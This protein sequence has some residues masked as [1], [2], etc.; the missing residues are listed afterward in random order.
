MTEKDDRNREESRRTLV[1]ETVFL[2]GQFAVGVALPID[3]IVGINRFSGISFASFPRV[4]LAPLSFLTVVYALRFTNEM[5]STKTKTKLELT[6]VLVTAVFGGF[7]AFYTWKVTMSVL[8]RTVPALI[9]IAIFGVIV[10]SLL[11]F[12]RLQ[13]DGRLNRQQ[14]RWFSR[15]QITR[16]DL[17]HPRQIIVDRYK[18]GYVISFL[19]YLVVFLGSGAVFVSTLSNPSTASAIITIGSGTVCYLFGDGLYELL[20]Q[21]PRHDHDESVK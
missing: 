20:R 19:F 6:F 17:R 15:S 10:G 1:L 13:Q 3:A 4:L 9:P 21:Q 5:V 11:L 18:L 16:H 7:I 2:A 8:I 12:R 14:E